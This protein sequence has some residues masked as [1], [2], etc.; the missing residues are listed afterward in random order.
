MLLTQADSSA[1]SSGDLP[2][3]NK[4]ISPVVFV[5]RSNT[6]LKVSQITY[7]APNSKMYPW[8]HLLSRTSNS[9]RLPRRKLGR[10]ETKLLVVM[11]WKSTKFLDIPLSNVLSKKVHLGVTEDSDVEPIGRSVPSGLRRNTIFQVLVV[12]AGSV[13]CE[14]GTYAAHDCHLGKIHSLAGCVE[15]ANLLTKHILLWFSK[16]CP[17]SVFCLLTWCLFNSRH[18]AFQE[19]LYRDTNSRFMMKEQPYIAD[20][21]SYW[22]HAH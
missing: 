15:R 9:R 14:I 16:Y 1:V 22:V 13:F 12:V 8:N 5:S 4:L 2:F 18:V 7:F 17:K 21:L 19:P 3:F 20:E 6:R 10:C 11:H